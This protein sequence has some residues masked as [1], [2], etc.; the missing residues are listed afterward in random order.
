MLAFAATV[1]FLGAPRAT[2][3]SPPIYVTFVWH[4]HQPIY[5]PGEDI[6]TTGDMGRYSFDVKEVHLGRYGPY[7]SWPRNAIAAARDQGLLG[8]GAQVSLTGSLM[9]NLDVLEAKGV[10]F[11]N[12]RASWEEASAWRTELDNPALDLIGFGYFHPLSALIPADDLML[13]VRLHREALK[14]RFPNYKPSKG[15]FPPETAFS[16]Q[17]IPALATAG[18]EWAVIDNVHFDRALTSYPYRRESNLIP[19]NRAD[20][21]NTN[22]TGWVNLR[23]LWAP[24]EVS[25]P[26]GYQP[27][28]ARYTDPST[29]KTS[30]IV[31][32]PAARYE[33]NEDARGGFGALQYDRVLSQLEPYN[34]DPNHPILVVLHHDGDNYGGGTDSYYHNNFQQFVQWIGNNRSR[35]ECTTVE[36]YLERFPP[37]QDDFIH[38]EDGS[39]S[40]ADNGDPE[41][42]KWN[43]DPAADGTSPDR[44]SWAVLTAAIN[45]VHTAVGD[46]GSLP[47]DTMLGPVAS[48]DAGS[49]RDAVEA[50]R[51][52]LMSEASD[53]WYWDR[54][55]NGLWDAHPTRAANLAINAIRG[56]LEAPG[57]SDHTPPTIYPPQREPYNPG[58]TEWATTPEA[59]ELGVWTFVDDVSGLAQVKLLYRIVPADA[60]TR[61]DGQFSDGTWCESEMNRSKFPSTSNPAPEAIADL[62]E[63]RIPGLEGFVVEYAVRATDLRGNEARSEINRVFVGPGTVGERDP[64]GVS[65]QVTLPRPD[66]GVGSDDAGDIGSDTDASRPSADGSTQADSGSGSNGDTDGSTVGGPDA[67][68]G[69]DGATTTPSADGD[70]GGCGCRASAQRQPSKDDAEGW[71]SLGLGISLGLSLMRRTRARTKPRT[72]AR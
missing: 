17:M 56:R 69:Q 18:V 7:T 23:D 32:V 34:N 40:G 10:G 66:G 12:W 60:V 2:K 67:G 21:R 65:C 72:T 26:F 15:I 36:D 11:S 19:P 28:R 53:Y 57:F 33:G 52:L 38:V 58:E 46:L 13:Q 41:F 8:C 43:A 61:D 49:A 30:Q 70:E 44:H 9:E 45:R 64:S 68:A 51:F 63:A 29:G 3:A 62:F 27:H 25:A 1:L 59:S 4:M 71:L 31:V 20:Q 35:F 6:V 22:D 50:V 37:A 47:L 24:G 55:E 48:S 42:L 16:R 14:K 39:W 5:W 54:S